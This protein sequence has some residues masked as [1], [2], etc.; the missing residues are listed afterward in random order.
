MVHPSERH[1]F[2][3]CSGWNSGFAFGYFDRLHVNRHGAKPEFALLSRRR[4]INTKRFRPMALTLGDHAL[5]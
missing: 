1:P 4:L 2:S 3:G 5:E